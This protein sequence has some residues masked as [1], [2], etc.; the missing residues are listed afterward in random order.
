V[1]KRKKKLEGK[2]VTG[3]GKRIEGVEK[4]RL[5]HKASVRWYALGTGA[6]PHV[7]VSKKETQSNI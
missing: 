2:G 5:W 1:G 7:W 4:K 3:E 6:H